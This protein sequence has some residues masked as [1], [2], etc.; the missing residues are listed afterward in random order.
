MSKT[1][2][3]PNPDPIGIFE[4]KSDKFISVRVTI[5]NHNQIPLLNITK[6][7]TYDS[8]FKLANDGM[9]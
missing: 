9:T 3:T 6:G 2:G 4:E 5:L 7:S 8:E 1:L